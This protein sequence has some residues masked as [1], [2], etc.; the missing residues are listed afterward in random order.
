[1]ITLK[2]EEYCHNDCKDFNPVVM[3]YETM[4][5]FNTFVSC[6]NEE[7]C[8]RICETIKSFKIKGMNDYERF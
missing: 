8:K 1:M 5:G 2:V 4:K 6:K 7:R 3:K